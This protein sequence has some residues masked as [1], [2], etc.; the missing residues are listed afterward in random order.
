MDKNKTC[1]ADLTPGMRIGQS[2]CS[3]WTV[4]MVRPYPGDANYTQIGAYVDHVP[5]S[6]DRVRYWSRPNA[7]IVRVVRPR[8]GEG[9][10]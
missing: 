5:Y 8:H 6:A 3:I 10:R 2:D 9:A 4:V 1:Y 7:E